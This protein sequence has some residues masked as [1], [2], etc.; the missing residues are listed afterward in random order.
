MHIQILTLE[1]IQLAGKVEHFRAE[2]GTDLERRGTRVVLQL[3]DFVGGAVGIHSDG[4]LDEF[5]GAGFENA[6]ERQ[7]GSTRRGRCGMGR[8]GEERQGARKTSWHKKQREN[9]YTRFYRG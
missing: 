4:D 6:T 8:R 1:V 9:Q 3:A 5:G 7:F 2:R